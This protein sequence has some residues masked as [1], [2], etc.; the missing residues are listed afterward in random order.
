MR[1]TAPLEKIIMEEI[2]KIN[3]E[4]LQNGSAHGTI[5]TKWLQS[6]QRID[7]YCKERNRY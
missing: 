5:I 3:S 4:I 6:L 7:A 2:Q 1:N